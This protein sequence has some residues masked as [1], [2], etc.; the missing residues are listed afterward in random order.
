MLILCSQ[1]LHSVY[2]QT[3]DAKELIGTYSGIQQNGRKHLKIEM[4]VYENA[5]DLLL[6]DVVLYD[7][8]DNRIDEIT[9]LT[10]FDSSN[11]NIR[12]YPFDLYKS[13][14]D[15]ESVPPT[16][17]ALFSKNALYGI[18]S[19]E[20]AVQA[21]DINVN[22]I[23]LSHT[24]EP[25]IVLTKEDINWSKGFHSNLF[26]ATHSDMTFDFSHIEFHALTEDTSSMVIH[27][28][29]QNTDEV[30]TYMLTLPIEA[31]PKHLV[32][33]AKGTNMPKGLDFM[34][35]AALKLPGD[36]FG[37]LEYT[38]QIKYHALEQKYESSLLNHV[39][40][41]SNLG[42]QNMT[43]RSYSGSFVSESNNQIAVY[44]D[45]S[46]PELFE[47][48]SENEMSLYLGSG[49]DKEVYIEALTTSENWDT[50]YKATENG[51]I[52][53][54][55]ISTDEIKDYVDAFLGENV[56]T[57]VRQQRIKHNEDTYSV[58]LSS[59]GS[60][61]YAYGEIKD[62]PYSAFI[63]ALNKNKETMLYTTSDADQILFDH[64][65]GQ[66]MIHIMTDSNGNEGS[67]SERPYDGFE[68]HK[69]YKEHLAIV[70][71]LLAQYE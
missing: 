19:T 45:L 57:L 21:D 44:F 25:K 69:K 32:T 68:N 43:Y 34:S 52:K 38:T 49:L 64:K 18:H 9:Y 42:S 41:D 20:H 66:K 35:Y 40:I 23:Y 60:G 46:L 3:T 70:L 67:Y 13:E 53:E 65:L 27:L 58:N 50:Y 71:D 22:S 5:I 48:L 24:S 55:P 30:F 61:H 62:A 28:D 39:S 56:D 59:M 12:L 10:L 7:L 14:G 8:H 2:A 51:Y 63:L 33:P 16:Y 11:S 54:L 36:T 17:I 47:L 6:T 4:S 37:P 31:T 26:Q 1:P 29:K 15:V